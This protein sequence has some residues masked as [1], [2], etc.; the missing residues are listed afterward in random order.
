MAQRITV[1]NLRALAA[2]LNRMTGSPEKSYSDNNGDCKFKAN[3]GNYH[4]SQAYGGYSLHRMLNDA[5]GVSE[6][7]T[8]GHVPAREL[9]YRIH[10]YIRGLQDAKELIA[11]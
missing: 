2:T 6:V 3:I 7:L 1:K 5:G 11:A 10:A 9:Y 4:I 8:S